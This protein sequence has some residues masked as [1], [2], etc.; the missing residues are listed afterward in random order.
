DMGNVPTLPFDNAVVQDY[1][2][3]MV[4]DLLPR[5][6][7]KELLSASFLSAG[8]LATGPTNTRL[9]ASPGTKA[10]EAKIIDVASEPLQAPARTELQNPGDPVTDVLSDYQPRQ[11]H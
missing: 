8:A 4:N 9:V 1:G 10:P 5:L 6:I 11:N 7:E 2:N 3:E